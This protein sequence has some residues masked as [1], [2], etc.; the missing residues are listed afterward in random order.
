MAWKTQTPRAFS[1]D[2]DRTARCLLPCP[3]ECAEE[4]DRAHTLPRKKKRAL[5]RA[6]RDHMR[7][8][9]LVARA[10]HAAAHPDSRLLDDIPQGKQHG[11]YRRSQ[12]AERV[13]DGFA[14]NPQDAY[15]GPQHRSCQ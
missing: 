11:R 12:Q 8:R 10:R 2:R 1:G 3:G 13:H 7:K 5:G 9:T 4:P 6:A 14:A 15:R